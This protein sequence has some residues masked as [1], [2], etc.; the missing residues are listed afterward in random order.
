MTSASTSRHR[1]RPL[2]LQAGQ[3]LRF[4]VRP[5]TALQVLAG[6]VRVCEPPRWLAERVISTGT[7]LHEAEAMRI[8]A[9]GW[10]E[11]L[12]QGG[13]AQVLAIEPVPA[14]ALLWR[15]LMPGRAPARQCA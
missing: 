3:A 1:I 4:C 5:G 9:G 6:S 11:L 13:E 2:R 10:I 15:R 12:A 14:W 7:T 8:E